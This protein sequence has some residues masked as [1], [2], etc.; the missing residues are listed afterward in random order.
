M[1]DDGQANQFAEPERDDALEA[2]VAAN[3]YSTPADAP[4]PMAPAPR[5]GLGVASGA[6]VGALAIGGAELLG[7]LSPLTESMPRGIGGASIGVLVGALCGRMIG[8]LLVARHHFRSLTS[9]HNELKDELRE[10]H[11]K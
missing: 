8:R 11:G 2:E 9:R 3:P 10:R 7:R 1:S 5:V 6:V 4:A